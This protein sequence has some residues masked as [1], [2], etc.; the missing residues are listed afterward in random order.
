MF[1][2][3]RARRRNRAA[4][5]R[6]KSVFRAAKEPQSSRQ[7]LVP[8]TKTFS[9]SDDEDDTLLPTHTSPSQK[10]FSS[11]TLLL[12]LNKLET[13]KL[14]QEI[15]KKDMLVKEL[16]ELQKENVA[17][18]EELKQEKTRLLQIIAEKEGALDKAKEDLTAAN[19]DLATA[20][21]NLSV[22]VSTLMQLQYNLHQ[23]EDVSPVDKAVDFGKRIMNFAF[24]TN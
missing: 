21:E 1:R 23:D 10:S 5:K 17:E 4:E 2:K 24:S 19:S 20:K 18:I 3:I 8:P 22:C 13:D 7:P 6:S 15:Q 16:K 12:S 9:M 14:K 11:G